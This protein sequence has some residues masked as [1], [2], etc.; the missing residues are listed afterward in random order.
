VTGHRQLQPAAE[1]RAMHGHHHR[2]W[3]ILNLLQQV[4][5]DWRTSSAAPRDLFETFDV[6]AGHEGSAGADDDDRAN[7]AVTG[8]RLEGGAET[9]DHVL[10][11]RID[12]RI[13]DADERD[14]IHVRDTHRGIHR[15]SS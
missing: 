12:R 15:H 4:V 3:H 11:E 5:D 6:S 14:P 10:G 13:I 1:R 2:L 7:R 9:V 8:H